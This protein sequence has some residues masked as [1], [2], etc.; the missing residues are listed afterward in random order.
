MLKRS[1]LVM[2]WLIGAACAG[3][4]STMS[5]QDTMRDWGTALKFF[6]VRGYGSGPEFPRALADIGEIPGVT[7][8]TKDEWGAELTYRRTD[9]DHY[10]LIS[11]GPNG[12][13]GDSDDIIYSNGLFYEPDKVY[14]ERPIRSDS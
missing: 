10:Q 5:T 9:L 4:L 6:Y 8:S 13:L 14:S 7:L 12:E 3:G 1:G 2:G 11:R